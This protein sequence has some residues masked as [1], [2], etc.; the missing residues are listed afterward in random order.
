LVLV[1]VLVGVPPAT[2]V[3]STTTGVSTASDA[4]LLE[5]RP[6]AA[7]LLFELCPAVDALASGAPRIAVGASRTSAVAALLLELRPADAA[8][9]LE[10]RPADAALASGASRIAAAAGVSRTSAESASALIA[11]TIGRN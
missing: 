7:A 5:L 3:R 2:F 4:L 11:S 8:L 9:L 10:L 1:T 6:A